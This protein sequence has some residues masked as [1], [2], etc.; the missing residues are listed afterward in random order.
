MKIGVSACLLGF[1]CR[2]DGNAKPH[3]GVIAAVEGHDVLPICPE[4]AGGLPI[5]HPACEINVDLQGALRVI[6]ADGADQTEPFARGAE[7]T[8]HDLQRF[9]ADLVIFKA[10]SP[11][12]GTGTVYDGTFSGT[13]REG[14]GVAA[15]LIRDAG[16]TCVDESTA[17]EAV[18]TN[19]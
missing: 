11:S 2:Y 16:F 9:E 17:V 15:R 19:A 14:W 7:A 6:D 4:V 8:L 10:K 1:A 5:P 3:S 13:L 12:C 18:N